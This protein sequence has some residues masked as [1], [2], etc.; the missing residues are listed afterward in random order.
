[1]KKGEKAEKVEEVEVEV[2]LE[3]TEGPDAELKALVTEKQASLIIERH[4][5]T[6]MGAGLVPIPIV[7]L[8]AVTGIQVSMIKKLSDLYGVEFSKNKTKNIVS[9]LIG[10]S[11]PAFTALPMVSLFQAVPVIGWGLGASSMSI[12]SGASTYAVGRVFNKHFSTGGSISNLDADKASSY[13]KEQYKQGKD[14]VGAF[15]KS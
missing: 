15:A 1:M 12:L 2:E 4:A 6:A 10:G 7:D 11:I 5:V 13:M 14:K 9:A 3:E 8:V